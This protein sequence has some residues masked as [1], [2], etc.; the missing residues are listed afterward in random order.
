M[1]TASALTRHALVRAGAGAAVL[2]LGVLVA[3]CA[4]P[5]PRVLHFGMEDAPEGRRLM[6]PAAP[7]VPRFM[8]AGQ[9]LGESNFVRTPAEAEGVGGLLRRIAALVVGEQPP[10]VLQRPQSGTVDA[11]GRIL[12][13]DASRQAVFV[14]DPVAGELQVWD[15]A[16]GLA[17]FVTPIGIATGADG[18]ILVADAQL[19]IVARLDSRGN[20]GRAIGRGVLKRPTGLAY[21]AVHKRIFVAD[22]HLHDIKVFDDDGQLLKVIGRQG[23]AAGEFNFPTFLAF[24]R[25][26]LYVADT[27]NSRIQ[28]FAD[29]GDRWRTSFGRRGLF[30]GNLV[31]PKG[32]TVDS[33][34]NIY[35]VESYHDHLL[36]FNRDGDFLMAIGGLGQE[37][38]RFYL[39]AG[40]WADSHN[41]VFVADMFNGRVVV[42][43]YLETG[44]DGG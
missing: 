5:A 3:A 44:G 26:E 17:N 16:E 18:Q 36:V 41:R 25:N 30:V 6:W 10:T 9:L 43:Q 2:A 42:F 24:A 19:G 12:V 14:F 4:A 32:I 33:D 23:D 11:A 22:T 31:R 39:P 27:M 20:P 38:G 35:V 34:G 7:E 40:A 37:T 28:V 15:K 1:S 29:G 13:T 8:F 21:D